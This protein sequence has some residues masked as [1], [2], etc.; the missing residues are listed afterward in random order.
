MS[1]ANLTSNKWMKLLKLSEM[2]LNMAIITFCFFLI[3]TFCDN[4]TSGFRIEKIQGSIPDTEEWKID[5]LFQNADL[6]CLGQPFYFLEKGGQAYAFISKD[7]KCVI[8][9]LK[10]RKINPSFSLKLLSMLPCFQKQ[11]LKKLLRLRKRIEKECKSYQIACEDLSKESGLIF[12]RLQKNYP[13]SHYVTV[14]DKIGMARRV[15]L[16]QVVC[17]V[18]KKASLIYPGLSQIIQT[19]GEK[20]A[21]MVI[22]NLIEFFIQRGKKGIRDLDPKINKNLGLVGSQAMQID[23]GRLCRDSNQRNPK[24]IHQEIKRIIIPL[25]EWLNLHHPSLAAY[26]NQRLPKD[27]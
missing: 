25:Q 5:V 11:Y 15:F 16:D 26:L 18:Q 9:F 14:V 12:A 7:K 3:K 10:F 22:D 6:S 2:L 19:E 27:C 1:S 8:K 24:I 17:I 21:Q 23:L 4:Q 20:G 13:L